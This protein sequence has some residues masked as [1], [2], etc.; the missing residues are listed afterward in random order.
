M[1]CMQLV[2]HCVVHVDFVSVSVKDWLLARQHYSSNIPVSRLMLQT[3]PCAEQPSEFVWSMEWSF[4]LGA[5]CLPHQPRLSTVSVRSSDSW[6]QG[7]CCFVWMQPYLE[8]GCTHSSAS[9]WITTTQGEG[10]R[11]SHTSMCVQ[12]QQSYITCTTEA[13]LLSGKSG[14]REIPLHDLFQTPTV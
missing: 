4:G 3:V 2:G 1:L 8:D 11:D 5:Y 14:W 10:G 13:S 6:W 12:Y 7:A 9:V